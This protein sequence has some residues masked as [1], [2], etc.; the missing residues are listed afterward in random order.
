ML[1]DPWYW[2]I[3]LWVVEC[4]IVEDEVETII[5][6]GVVIGADVIDVVTRTEDDVIKVLEEAV[7]CMLLVLTDVVS[8]FFS[9]DVVVDID[10]AVISLYVGLV[11]VVT[12]TVDADRQSVP[13]H[14]I[15]FLL[16]VVVDLDDG[17]HSEPEQ[18]I[19]AVVLVET[20]PSN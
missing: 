16:L 1:A 3:T 19:V 18:I 8:M 11:D 4:W 15:L 12:R 17:R 7:F 2:L 13:V 5:T 10:D 9:W 6:E 20:V 14:W